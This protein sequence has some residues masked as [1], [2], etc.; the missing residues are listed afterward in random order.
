MAY[1]NQN[2]PGSAYTFKP[3]MPA[4]V[5]VIDRHNKEQ[6]AQKAA[7]EAAA[8]EQG[9]ESRKSL[10]DALKYNPAAP[11]AE[12]DAQIK[13]LVNEQFIP[14]VAA[15][16][17]GGRL[18]AAHELADIE[19]S[20]KDIEIRIG[21][22]QAAK[23]NLS[24]LLEQTKGD[25]EINQDFVYKAVE[26]YIYTTDKDG[27]K[28]LKEVSDLD[29]GSIK[30]I[31]S[32]PEAYNRESVI[33]N[34]ANSIPA[35]MESIIRENG[36][37][38]RPYRTHKN[39]ESKFLILDSEGNRQYDENGNILLNLTPETL[40]LAYGNG[41]TRLAKLIDQEVTKYSEQGQE[42]TRLQAF[43][44]LMAHKAYLKEEE[45]RTNAT[46]R[47]SDDTKGSSFIY[48]NK[49]LH[50]DTAAR[51]DSIG[52]VLMNQDVQEL[53][54][55]IGEEAKEA[56]FTNT[57]PVSGNKL[58]TPHLLIYTKS[59]ETTETERETYD[60]E[61]NEV[62]TRSKTTGSK[63]QVFDLSNPIE[64]GKA[65]YLINELM[66]KNNGSKVTDDNLKAYID[67]LKKNE[68]AALFEAK[69]AKKESGSKLPSFQ[70]KKIGD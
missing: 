33:T 31:L 59:N 53:N 23:D 67:H 69:Y 64:R 35:N 65:L 42:V 26:D 52:R 12:Y 44:N 8:A 16:H 50:N 6:S 55:I 17:K 5:T 38:T 43:K 46:V 56:R 22:I 14:K 30:D 68:P 39:I 27:N 13:Q 54:R 36:D 18:P 70:P 32:A 41:E 21:K 58:K 48:G 19:R 2:V 3:S 49:K 51:Y 40:R 28:A 60:S 25:K 10:I 15:Y 29:P 57:H 20:K 63:P 37:P 47:E 1:Y 66:T 24:E 7:Q 4:P 62:K 11:M 61:G 34:F 9:K 45:K